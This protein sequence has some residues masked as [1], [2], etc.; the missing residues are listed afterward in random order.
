MSMRI[1][2]EQK[3]I[4]PIMSLWICNRLFSAFAIFI[5][6]LNGSHPPHQYPDVIQ[7]KPPVSLILSSIDISSASIR[8]IS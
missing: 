3:L 8:A 7:D 2:F 5:Y 6:L 4:T 1:S